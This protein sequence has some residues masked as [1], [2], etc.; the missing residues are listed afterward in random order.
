MKPDEKED[1]LK[2]FSEE[3]LNEMGM[4][5]VEGG[6]GLNG[7]ANKSCPSNNNC[8]NCAEGCGVPPPPKEIT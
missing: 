6:I 7:T 8:L 2:A 5:N 1:A 3:T 4:E